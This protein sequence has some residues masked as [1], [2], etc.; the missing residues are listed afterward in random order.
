MELGKLLEGETLKTLSS[1]TE[2][3]ANDV[4][5]IDLY[6]LYQAAIVCFIS[7]SDPFLC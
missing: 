1:H 5:E 7:S 2:N 3:R 6:A 4:T